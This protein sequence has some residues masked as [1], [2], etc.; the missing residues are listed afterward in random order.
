M[1]YVLRLGRRRVVTSVGPLYKASDKEREGTQE[2]E[3][4]TH[5]NRTR[6]LVLEYGNWRTAHELFIPCT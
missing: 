3:C 1:T 4:E 2:R 5:C 6:V